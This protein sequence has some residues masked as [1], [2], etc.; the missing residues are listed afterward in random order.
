MNGPHA[1]GDDFAPEVAASVTAQLGDAGAEDVGVFRVDAPPF[2]RA[3]MFV[4]R[5]GP[6]RQRAQALIEMALARQSVPSQVLAAPHW[7]VATYDGVA[8]LVDRISTAKR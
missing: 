6:T 4:W 1:P 2:D 3:F 5:G 8:F 7:I